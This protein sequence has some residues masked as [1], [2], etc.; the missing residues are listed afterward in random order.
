MKHWYDDPPLWMMVEPAD[1]LP[2]EPMQEVLPR[3]VIAKPWKTTRMTAG[4]PPDC[5]KS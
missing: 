2:Q 1:K 3:Q 4:K 5:F